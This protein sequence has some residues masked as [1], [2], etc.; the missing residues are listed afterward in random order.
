M[1]KGPRQTDGAAGRR[2]RFALH[3]R[4]AGKAETEE[5]RHLV[6]RFPGRVVKRPAE[7]LKFQRR[8][9]NGTE[10]YGRR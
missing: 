6:E 9:G 4:A 10:W 3:G 2:R 1:K 5:A 7:Q 8:R